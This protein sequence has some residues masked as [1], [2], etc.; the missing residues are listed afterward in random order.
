MNNR[1]KCLILGAGGDILLGQSGQKP[2]Q[3]LLTREMKWNRLEVVAISPEPGA[4]TAFRRER[5]MLAPKHFR[6]SAHRLV[7]I[8]SAILIQEPLGV[9]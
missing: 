6:K 9:Y 3:F 2:F 4:V 1:V 7:G 5:K 8:Q